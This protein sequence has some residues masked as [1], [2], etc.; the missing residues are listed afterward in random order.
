MAFNAIL[1]GYSTTQ[2]FGNGSSTSSGRVTSN[3]TTYNAVYAA[4]GAGLPGVFALTQ[5]DILS[6]ADTNKFKTLMSRTNL[7]LNGQGQSGLVANVMANTAAINTITV[8]GPFAVGSTA[9][10]YG[11]RSV[12][13]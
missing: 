4:D 13:Q 5:V 8:F 6:Y 11:V 1:T 12:G 7:D 2:L 10:L 3:T 9:T